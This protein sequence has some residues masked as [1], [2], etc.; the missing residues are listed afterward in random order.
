MRLLAALLLAAL[1]LC[2]TG[3]GQH[4]Y[5]ASVAAVSACASLDAA[6]SWGR[7]ELNPV[8]AGRD[9]RFGGRGIAIKAGITGAWLGAQWLTRRR[10]R[11]AWTVGNVAIAASW[12]GAAGWN[13][14][15]R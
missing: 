2:Q 15:S 5:R 10:D 4:A 13:W 1:C 9:Q 12:C 7:V 8:L 14:A 11:R 6:S 3:S